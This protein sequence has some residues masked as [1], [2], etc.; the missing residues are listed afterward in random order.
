MSDPTPAPPEKW[1]GNP[2]GHCEPQSPAALHGICIFCWRDRGAAAVWA[3]RAR[4]ERAEA[5]AED[6]RQYVRHVMDEARADADRRV[7]EALEPFRL[8]DIEFRALE[9]EPYDCWSDALVKANRTL[10]ALA[11][12]PA[13][14]APRG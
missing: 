1:Q 6:A 13:E 8:G 11:G 14:E 5:D 3:L 2:C 4:L 12:E 7:A 10:R 9:R